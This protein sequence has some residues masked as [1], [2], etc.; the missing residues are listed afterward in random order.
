M[1]TTRYHDGLC[2]IHK[3]VV[4]F[5]GFPSLPIASK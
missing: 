3:D 5:I 4:H 1:R 2:P